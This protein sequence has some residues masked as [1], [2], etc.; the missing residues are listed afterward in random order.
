VEAAR[1]FISLLWSVPRYSAGM[2]LKITWQLLRGVEAG[3]ALYEGIPAD[4][5]LTFGVNGISAEVIGFSRQHHRKS[6]LCIGQDSDLDEVFVTPGRNR[7]ADGVFGIDGHCALTDADEI[8]VQTGYQLDLLRERFGR[9]GHLIL[10][11]IDLEADETQGCVLEPDVEA[12][13]A[14]GPFILWV[15]RSDPVYKRP[16]VCL[17]LAR[18]LPQVRFVMVMGRMN[19]EFHAELKR[20]RPA[21]VE[22]IDGLPFR[23][24][25]HLFRASLALVSTSSQEGFPNI[26]LQA[27]KYNVPVVSLNVDPDG[28]FSERRAGVVCNGNLDLMGKALGQL[29]SDPV[30]RQQYAERLAKYVA[31]FHGLE[32]RC[33]EL[34]EI[35]RQ[36]AQQDDGEH[37]L[38]SSCAA[39][40]TVRC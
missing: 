8:V 36:T 26:F 2:L 14:Q 21:N 3:P 13:V 35:V 29:V 32:G 40:S 7:R 33:D 23:A 5:F 10:N 38:H 1:R 9:V 12:V 17:E 18:R 6:I 39:P 19:A 24:M 4:V 37:A 27:G 16:D 25:P 28:I 20:R 22:I 34:C 15:G 30:Q 11:P 31:E